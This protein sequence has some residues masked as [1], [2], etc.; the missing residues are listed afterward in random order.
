LK[1]ES[2]AKFSPLGLPFLTS[3]STDWST[4]RI[5]LSGP[6]FLLNLDNTAIPWAAH[7]LQYRRFFLG[8]GLS[9]FDVQAFG[10]FGLFLNRLSRC[11]LK[12]PRGFLGDL[13]GESFEWKGSYSTFLA[14]DKVNTAKQG[15]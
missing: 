10:S 14:K 3:T 8:V 4:M 1:A 9:T 2:K 15:F 5:S 7:P 11:A 6:T 13:L 12:I